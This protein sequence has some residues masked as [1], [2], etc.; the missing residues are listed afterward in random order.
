MKTGI[1][2]ILFALAISM[3]AFGSEPPNYGR[4]WNMWTPGERDAYLN[5]VVDGV[6]RA[7]FVTLKTVAPKL[8][9]AKQEPASVKATTD[10]LFVR[11]TRE[12]LPDVISYL[13]SDPANA[14]VSTLDMF[15]LARDK[16][17]GK[18][19]SKGLMQ[20]RHDAM[21]SHEMNEE[22]RQNQ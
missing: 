22:I 15:F 16:I 6:A 4:L 11:Y 13:Y 21:R 1:A 5:G 20:A 17:E 9:N 19:I 18:D 14:Y 12:Q 7:Y 3:P 8:F 10:A 2:S